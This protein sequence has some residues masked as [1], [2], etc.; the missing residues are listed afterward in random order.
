MYIFHFEIFW[1]LIGPLLQAFLT[2]LK[3]SALSMM[4]GMTI[5]LGVCFC[6]MSKRAVL[7]EAGTFYIEF[8]QGMPILVL[9][10]WLYYGL[11]MLMGIAFSAFLSGVAALTLKFAGY[12]A[13]IFRAGIQAIKAGQ[14]EA[15][16]SLGFSKIQTM[17]RIVLPQ[18]FRIVMPP[19]G[20]NFVGMVQSSALVSV[21]G[22]AD[23]MREAQLIV[24]Y[25]WRPFEVYTITTIIYLAAT[26]S[27]SKINDYIEKRISVSH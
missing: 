15:A 10:F 7:R 1:K 5:G 19:I 23:L 24:T 13:E 27:I 4:L 18:A 9:I 11:P 26:I 14:I 21:I 6:K 16:Y 12:L 25:T 8:A 3:V 2:T 22:V 20:N 17:R